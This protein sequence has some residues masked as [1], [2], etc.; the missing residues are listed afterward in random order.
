MKINMKKLAAWMLALLLV[1][2]MIPAMADISNIIEGSGP[3]VLRSKLQIKS[4]ATILEVGEEYTMEGDSDYH[5][6]WASSNSDIASVDPETG[7][8]TATGTG[9]V[10]ITATEGNNNG[11]SFS[12]SITLR[13][14][15]AE[16]KEEKVIIM[17]SGNHDTITY[18]GDEHTAGYEVSSEGNYDESKLILV[19]KNKIAKATNCGMYPIKFTEGDFIYDVDGDGKNDAEI[20]YSNGWMKINRA[21]ATLNIDD[22]TKKEGEPDPEFTASVEGLIGEDKL[23]YTL[24]TLPQDG[25]TYIVPDEDISEQGNYRV[26]VNKGTLTVEPNDSLNGT[27]LLGMPFRNALLTATEK[28]RDKRL[29]AI[30]YAV[31]KDNIITADIENPDYWTFAQ[32]ADGTYYISSGGKYL[33]IKEKAAT[34]GSDPQ[35]MTVTKLDNGRIVI[36]NAANYALNLKSN[37]VDLGFQGYTSSNGENEQF[38]LY[39]N[40]IWGKKEN[41]DLYYMLSVNGG[42]DFYR[43]KK[44]TIYTKPAELYNHGTKINKD[45]Y[46]MADYDFTDVTI[47]I[48]GETYKYSPTQLTGEFES[49]FTVEFSDVKKEDRINGKLDWFNTSDGW[50]DGSYEQYGKNAVNDTVGYHAN[51]KA[52]TYKGNKE[53]LTVRIQSNVEHLEEVESGTEII[54]T[55]VRGGTYKGEVAIT[56]EREDPEG[57]RTLIEGENEMSYKFIIDEENAKYKYYITLTPVE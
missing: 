44:G 19:N 52:K 41:R 31:G 21:E 50:L 43:L 33:N 27:Y 13:V 45:D 38:A 26:T 46:E 56:W 29:A 35:P 47:T 40:Y 23:N 42:S 51:Y 32:Q 57:N 36:K 11:T 55:G 48:D 5:L 17:I 12:D 49:Y 6:T 9:T 8:V 39:S 54:L 1:F 2:Q 34:M 30:K 16:E 3:D 25:T 28:T 24:T 53:T 4:P 14:I 20:E 15:A 10:K 18:D 37:N 7:V 22:K